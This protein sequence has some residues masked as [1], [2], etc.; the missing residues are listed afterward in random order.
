[1]E[2]D[3]NQL[4]FVEIPGENVVTEY[5]IQLTEDIVGYIWIPIAIDPVKHIHDLKLTIVGKKFI[6]IHHIFCEYIDNNY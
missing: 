6:D 4:F 3:K 5:G 1:M 2:N